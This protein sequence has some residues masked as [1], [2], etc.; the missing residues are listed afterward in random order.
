MLYSINNIEDLKNLEEL[1]SLQNQV[2]EVRLQD[3]LGKQ[4]YHYDAKKSEEPLIDTIK[5]TSENLTKTLK[6]TYNDNNKA[7]EN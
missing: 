5:D 1:D 4:N 2:N 7:I 6:G 3:K